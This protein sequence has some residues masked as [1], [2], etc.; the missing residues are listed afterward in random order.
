VFQSCYVRAVNK[1]SGQRGDMQAFY[2]ER[3]GAG[4]VDMESA[5][6]IQ[7]HVCK[8]VVSREDV[9]LIREVLS[10]DGVERVNRAL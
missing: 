2:V 10:R 4:P 7:P 1:E 6:W 8:K 3:P 9:A 5:D